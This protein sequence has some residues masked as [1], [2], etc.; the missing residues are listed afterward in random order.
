MHETIH[1]EK[2]FCGPAD[3]GQGGYIAGMLS[4]YVDGTAL[5]TEAGELC[6]RG[7]AT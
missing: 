1:I 2:K 4:K 6:A 7:K 5:F 3:S